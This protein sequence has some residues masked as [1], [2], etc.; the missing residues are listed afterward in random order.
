ERPVTRWERVAPSASSTSC[1][2]T[3]SINSRIE[4]RS[5]SSKVTRQGLGSSW[6]NC[7]AVL[8]FAMAYSSCSRDLQRRDPGFVFNDFSGE[9][10]FHFSTGIGT[11]PPTTAAIVKQIRDQREGRF[12][13]RLLPVSNTRK[14][15][16]PRR[17]GKGIR[18]VFSRSGLN[19]CKEFHLSTSREGLQPSQRMEVWDR[20]KTFAG[21]FSQ[22]KTVL[23]GSLLRSTVSRG[24]LRG[25]SLSRY[26]SQALSSL[27]GPLASLTFLA[28][29]RDHYNGRYLHEGWASF[30]SPAE[31]H[32][33][34]RSTHVAVFESL[35]GLSVIDLARAL[36]SHILSLAEEEARA[37]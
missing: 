10:A 15:Q 9:Y 34:L 24:M 21:S 20:V 29:M 35:L 17:W 12:T 37:V 11:E 6:R 32:E 1:S 3:I 14:L 23:Q 4:S 31:V 7:G 22:L 36:R 26:L 28:S 5:F 19:C 8:L 27:S 25:D 13:P 33:M 16:R 2:R 30:G 18:A